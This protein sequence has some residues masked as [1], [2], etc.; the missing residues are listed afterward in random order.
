LKHWNGPGYVPDSGIRL[1]QPVPNRN[2]EQ[3]KG[4]AAPPAAAPVS[5]ISKRRALMKD[6]QTTSHSDGALALT[7]KQ[8]TIK[9]DKTTIYM[10]VA[11]VLQSAK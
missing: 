11:G 7:S 8:S 10:V 4:P 9:L 5:S 6:V 3:E 2:S 1:A